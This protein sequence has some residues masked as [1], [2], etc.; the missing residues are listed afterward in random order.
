MSSNQ[1]ALQILLQKYQI[2]SAMANRL[3]TLQNFKVC[4]ILDDS[5][6]MNIVDSQEKGT[7]RWHELSNF[8]KIVIEIASMF[9]SEGV[10]VHFLN[11]QP[12]KKVRS[13]DELSLYFRDRPSGA[14]PLSRTIQNVIQENP[15]ESLN[16]RNL[17][18][19]IATDGEPTDATGYSNIPEFKQTLRNRPNYVYTNIAA[20]TDDD[21]SIGYL[22]GL[23]RELP[24]LDVI[25]DYAMELA[26]VKRKNGPDFQFSFGDYATKAILG[27]ISSDLDISDEIPQSI[28]SVLQKYQITDAMA[29]RLEVLRNY[30]IALVLDDSSTMNKLESNIR[31]TRWQELIEAANSMIEIVS[32]F[33]PNGCDVNFL[34][35]MPLKNVRD[36]NQLSLFFRD[37]PGT[38]ILFVIRQK[39]FKKFHR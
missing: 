18:I 39:S 14:T 27:S 38:P 13:F 30:K 28:S 8:A 26:E 23:D 24:R 29:R 15:V 37:P 21:S 4:L 5:T 36:I 3:K 19:L 32:V 16:N 31:R 9:T 34:N 7:S 25:D 6:S 1:A 33:N 20:C 22:N 10:D 2:S 11:M 35:M 12:V 17:L